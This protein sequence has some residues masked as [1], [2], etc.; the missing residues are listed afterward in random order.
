M[1]CPVA[2]LQARGRGQDSLP[3]STTTKHGMHASWDEQVPIQLS[4]TSSISVSFSYRP[5]PLPWPRLW[6]RPPLLPVEQLAPMALPRV[7]EAS[8]CAPC[9]AG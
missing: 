5:S 1:Y 8:C 2:Q 6:F 7:S 9:G 3:K 4:C